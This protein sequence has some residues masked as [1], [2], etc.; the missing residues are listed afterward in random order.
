VGPCKS[1]TSQTLSE[2]QFLLKIYLL[3][4]NYSRN[5]RILSPSHAPPRLPVVFLKIRSLITESRAALK[6]F[7]DSGHESPQTGGDSGVQHQ[8]DPKGDSGFPTAAEWRSSLGRGRQGGR[9]LG[10]LQGISAPPSRAGVP[11]HLGPQPGS[12]TPPRTCCPPELPSRCGR[13][14][15]RDGGQA[16]RVG[17]RVPVTV[18]VTVAL[19]N[20]SLTGTGG[21]PRGG[22][23]SAGR[24]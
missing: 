12:A 24:T 1:A 14:R 5:S 22:P 11:T 16:A 20:A 9:G 15:E 8:R 10:G 23:A 7:A 2:T 18:T 19:G 3:E 17:L 6:G 21:R 4:Y 13:G